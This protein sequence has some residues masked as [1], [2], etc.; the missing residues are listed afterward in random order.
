MQLP[1][2]FVEKVE[3]QQRPKERFC[4]TGWKAS[5]AHDHASLYLETQRIVGLVYYMEEGPLRL[6]CVEVWARCQSRGQIF[7]LFPG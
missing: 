3:D 6:G 1:G 5:P 7:A 2:C 4:L